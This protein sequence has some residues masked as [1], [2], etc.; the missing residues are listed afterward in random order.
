MVRKLPLCPLLT[1]RH[2]SHAAA[3]YAVQLTF[4]AA[5]DH[6]FRFSVTLHI[7]AGGILVVLILFHLDITGLQPVNAVSGRKLLQ[8]VIVLRVIHLLGKG[9]LRTRSTAGHGA[10]LAGIPLQRPR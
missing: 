2:G 8:A 3:Y 5:G 4:P 9:L 6:G 10:S 7:D 1:E